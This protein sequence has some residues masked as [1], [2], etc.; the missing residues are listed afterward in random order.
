M[1]QAEVN[2]GMLGHVDH[3]KTTLTEKLS[4]KWTGTHSEEIKRGISI[5]LGYA[6]M[7]VYFCTKCK[8]YGN[9]EKCSVCGTT[10]EFKRKISFIDA[11]G[12]ETLM[13]TVIAASSILDGA[14]FLIS[15][16]EECPQPQTTEHL[17]VLNS[18]GI[19][20][21]VVVQTKVDLVSKEKALENYNQ[22]KAFL[23]GTVAE[24]APIIPVSAN[25][26]VNMDLLIEAIEATIPTPE[27][28]ETA[29]LKM[30][31]S[32]SFDVNKPGNPIEKLK[33]GVIGGSIIQGVLKKGDRIELKLGVARRENELPTPLQSDVLVLMGEKEALTEAKPGGLIAVG[34][35]IDPALTKSDAL[36]GSVIGHVGELPDA[37][38]TAKVKYELIKR[39]DMENPPLKMDEVLALNLNTATTVG[40][41][42]NLA[43]GIATI[44]LKK[45]IVY[46]KSARVA[47]S[48]RFG[49]RWKLAGWGTLV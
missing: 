49:Q 3:G 45:P 35:S 7:S 28:D 46:D 19:K 30:F 9:S 38:S 14:L 36:I 39:K 37:I 5:R 25:Y 42:T 27:R 44:K 24:N 33:G 18:I 41:V 32:R 1:V 8:K 40:V 34:T 31:V 23:K 26:N 6:D 13:T 11:P 22:I 15:A 17:V 10:G 47:L 12:H 4:G 43:K 2:I 21:I 29:P 20:N 16:N 48:R